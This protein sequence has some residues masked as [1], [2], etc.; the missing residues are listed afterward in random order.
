MNND[1]HYHVGVIRSKLTRN[2]ASTFSQVHDELEASL[3][4]FIPLPNKGSC[5]IL[6][7]KN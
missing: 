7:E 2:I 5:G 4:E 3:R 6:L 1:D